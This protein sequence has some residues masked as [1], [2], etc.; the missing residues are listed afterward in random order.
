MHEMRGMQ[1][2]GMPIRE[3]LGRLVAGAFADNFSRKIDYLRISVTDRCN[4]KCLYC[5]PDGGLRHFSTSSILTTREIIRFAGAALRHGV[6]KVRITGGE[7]L[8]RGDIL[9]LVESIKGLGIKD[10][11]ITTNGLML[12]EMAG[13]LKKAG[14]DRV[15]ISLDTLKAD[16]Y[17]LLTRGGELVHVWEAIQAAERS[18]LSPVKINVVP[19]RDMNDDEVVEFA[20]LTMEK[21]WHI[22]FIELMPVGQRGKWSSEKRVKKAE[23]IGK[24]SVLGKLSIL[25]YRGKGPSRNYRLEG[26]KGVI[27]F[28]SPIS[29]CFCQWCNRLRLTANGRIRPCLFSDTEVDIITPMRRGA[30]DEQLDELFRRAVC[31]KPA[32]HRLKDND[33]SSLSSM[34]KIGG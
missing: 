15:N 10:L 16:R 5:M 24:I 8:L 7:P 34:S 25:E 2:S 13:P 27:G 30:S 32:G 19:I 14:L 1:I 20:R 26:A 6:S 22:R 4:L 29:E 17:K 12:A 9:E 11:S 28:I 23:L 18:G 3:K 31:L 21:D 33:F